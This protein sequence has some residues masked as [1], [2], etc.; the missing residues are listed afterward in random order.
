MQHDARTLAVA[1][2]TPLT[3]IEI[4]VRD[5]AS[6]IALVREGAG[7]S[8]VP[9]IDAAGNAAGLTGRQARATHLSDVRARR[10]SRERAVARGANLHRS[11]AIK[12]ARSNAGYAQ[13]VTRIL[14]SRKEPPSQGPSSA[15]PWRS[16]SP[17]LH[18]ARDHRSSRA[19]RRPCTRQNPDNCGRGS[20]PRSAL[21]AGRRA[22]D[23]P[24]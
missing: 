21:P 9:G 22:R 2:G 12:F 8:L 24:R 11:R 1:A 18:W 15:R 17:C 3:N 5:L 10:L 16:R 20:P 23:R 14:Q 13:G 19:N 4:E 6:A 7:L